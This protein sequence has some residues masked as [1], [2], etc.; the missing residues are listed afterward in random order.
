MIETNLKEEKEQLEL[1]ILTLRNRVNALEA[2]VG[3]VGVN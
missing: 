2:V 3:K 1:L